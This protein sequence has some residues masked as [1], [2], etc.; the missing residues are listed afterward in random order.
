MGNAHVVLSFPRNLFIKY[1]T[2]ESDEGKKVAANLAA[3]SLS[4]DRYIILKRRVNFEKRLYLSKV[5]GKCSFLIYC[6]KPSK[7]NCKSVNSSKFR[8][9]TFIL[10]GIFLQLSQNISQKEIFDSFIKPGTSVPLPQVPLTWEVITHSLRN[11]LV[12]QESLVLKLH[13]M[14]LDCVNKSFNV[15]PHLF[16]CMRQLRIIEY[17]QRQRTAKTSNVQRFATI[18]DE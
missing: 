17:V 14:I 11:L 1:K 4:I 7:I 13:T 8:Y 12:H 18:V 16:I 5:S 10:T 15:I 9:I 6:Q 3:Y 2:A